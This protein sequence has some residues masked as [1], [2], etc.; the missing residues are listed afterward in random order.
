MIPGGPLEE[1]DRSRCG[2]R[3]ATHR[4]AAIR[5]YCEQRL[6]RR[7]LH[8]FRVEAIVDGNT[9]TIVERRAPWRPDFEPE[10]STGPGRSAA[11]RPQAPALGAAVARS[12]PALA[13][14]RLRQ[15]DDGCDCPA[16]RDR[17]RSDLHLLGL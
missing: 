9:V 13:S 15:A 17:E 5:S 12:Q 1:H 4:L 8:Q 14:L 3:S 7:A 11:L 6:P 10:W 16:R 2:A